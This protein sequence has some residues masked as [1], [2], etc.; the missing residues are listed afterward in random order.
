MEISDLHPPATISTGKSPRYLQDRRL[1]ETQRQSRHVVVMEEV[2]AWQESKPDVQHVE[3][4]Y[5]DVFKLTAIKFC[6]LPRCQNCLGLHF[7]QLWLLYYSHGRSL[8]S[9]IT[10][11]WQIFGN[12]PHTTWWYD[13]VCSV[14]DH[15]DNAARTVIVFTGWLV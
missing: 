3:S 6:I 10:C 1:H 9:P 12:F 13:S 5:F 4:C 2:C 15:P 14:R 11:L 7:Y 8:Y